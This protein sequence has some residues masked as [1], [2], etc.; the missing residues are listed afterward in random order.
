MVEI[1]KL[2]AG[3]L[4]REIK[5]IESEKG[6]IQGCFLMEC[7]RLLEKELELKKSELDKI[8]KKINNA[9]IRFEFEF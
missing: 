7:E 1:L 2:K 6:Q 4:E 9:T 3:I 5:I 8:N